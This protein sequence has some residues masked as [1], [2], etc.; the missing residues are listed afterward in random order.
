M[1]IGEHSIAISPKSKVLVFHLRNLV[2]Y[3]G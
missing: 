3:R 1:I 2:L